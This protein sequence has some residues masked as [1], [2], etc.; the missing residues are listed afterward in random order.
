[1]R[2]LAARALVGYGP[3]RYTCSRLVQLGALRPVAP[4]RPVVLELV[5]ES[6]HVASHDALARAIETWATAQTD[7]PVPG[8]NRGQIHGPPGT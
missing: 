6:S 1:M 5:G 8:R 7:V 4:G 2:E 3:A